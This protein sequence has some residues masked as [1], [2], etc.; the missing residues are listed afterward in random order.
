MY[1]YIEIC[2]KLWN[3]IYMELG[4]CKR[5]VNRE[6]IFWFEFVFYYNC[7]C[8]NSYI[9]FKVLKVVSCFFDNILIKFL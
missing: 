8:L 9:I 1:G 2:L 7:L 5:Y 6:E 3:L 4:C